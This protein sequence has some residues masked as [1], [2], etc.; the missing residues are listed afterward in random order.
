MK[1]V[2]ALI[3]GILVIFGVSQVKADELDDLLQGKLIEYDGTCRFDK[4]DMLVF[5]NSDDMK[6]VRCVVG[7]MPPDTDDKK[8]VLL[9]D[10]VGPAILLE[11]SKVKKA[12]RKLWVRGAL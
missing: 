9:F 10:A 1:E 11:Y 3:I 5:K 2:W 12:Q 7:F 6:V 8:F 4:N